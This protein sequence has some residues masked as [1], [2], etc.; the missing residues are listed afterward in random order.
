MHPAAEVLSLIKAMA[1]V[2]P[3]PDS[4]LR[5]SERR[6]AVRLNLEALAYIELGT[7][8]GGVILN[9]SEGG[10]ALRAAIPVMSDHIP[11]VRFHL[12]QLSNVFE[13]ECRITWKS[14]DR[15]AIG[16]SF[17]NPSDSAR[18]QIAQWV[19]QQIPLPVSAAS[20]FPGTPPNAYASPYAGAE[21]VRSAAPAAMPAEA[22]TAVAAFASAAAEIQP[23]MNE[24][25]IAP[26]AGAFVQAQP[27]TDFASAPN[28]THFGNAAPLMPLQPAAP[29]VH[30]EEP[31]TTIVHESVSPFAAATPKPLTMPAA[32]ANF[33]SAAM[34]MAAHNAPEEQSEAE[35]SF[36]Q[37]LRIPT[38]LYPLPRNPAAEKPKTPLMMPSHIVPEHTPVYR[39]DPSGLKLVPPA[40]IVLDAARQAAA[41]APAQVQP[42]APQAVPV[43]V[44]PSA[45]VLISVP[46][47][48]PAP[49]QQA[50]VPV[51]SAEMQLAQ[52]ATATANLRNAVVGPAL[53]PDAGRRAAVVLAVKDADLKSAAW[54]LVPGTIVLSVALVLAGWSV[55]RGSIS[56]VRD[57][58]S[59][60]ASGPAPGAGAKPGAAAESLQIQV[61][62]ADGRD[63]TIPWVR[64][65]DGDGASRAAQNARRQNASGGG[66]ANSRNANG[67]ANRASLNATSQPATKPAMTVIQG[68]PA[69]PFNSGAQPP[70]LPASVNA[71]NLQPRTGAGS[72]GRQNTNAVKTS[73][74]STTTSSRPTANSR[75]NAASSG[76]GVFNDANLVDAPGQILK[77]TD[78][79]Y[80]QDAI[81]ARIEGVVELEAI[82]M[83]DG[84]V[85]DVKVMSGDKKLAPAAVAAVK[86]WRFEPA[87][88][89]GKLVESKQ[90][91]RLT[92]RLGDQQ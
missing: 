41:H 72:S 22:T 74:A 78:P 90:D 24:A 86:Q 16:V 84:S 92:F 54:I 45:G 31:R 51:A 64:P 79:I 2:V 30:V 44:Q 52:Q 5:S 59:S 71:T 57:V 20:Q 19:R 87:V 49:A 75:T 80:P 23:V 47:Q 70:E 32:A 77:R 48:P 88:V 53:R 15:R 9:L 28:E 63:R 3:N 83:R 12:P 46:P 50:L 42:A 29:I 11:A 10:L 68:T 35:A 38:S 33:P 61:E 8:N 25:P 13:I 67:G 18:T 76:S 85:R 66:A 34:Q 65:E 60:D 43:R 73:I 39:P 7:N 81:N 40:A 56:A 36:R 55:G 27:E 69:A 26:T 21:Q 37:R 4:H 82:I 14:E 6:R 58:F 17:V 89:D 91:V 62:N 1:S